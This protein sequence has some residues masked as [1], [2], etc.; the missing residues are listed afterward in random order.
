L[1]A[2]LD[3]IYIKTR[4]GKA[5]VRLV[6]H[7]FFQGRF[8]TTKHR[9]L[10]SF[11]LAEMRF[12]TMLPPLKSANG[13]IYIMGM[14]RSG[15]TI[16]G[17]VL[18]MHRQVGFLNEPKLI[19]YSVDPK[20]DVNGNF[21]NGPAQYR[22][23]VG[24]ASPASRRRI[25]R[26]YSFYLTLTG[27]RRIVDKNPEAVYRIPYLRE[28][29]P[30]ARF[31]FLVRNGWDTVYSTTAWS[32]REGR[33]VKGVVED[34]WGA[35]QRK[36]KF[37]VDQLVPTDPLLSARQNEIAKFNRHE[38]MAA[39][40]WTISVREG[41][42]WLEKLPRSVHLIRYEHLTE[43]PAEALKALLDFCELPDDEVFL[44][45]A[46]QVLVPGRTHNAQSDL[47]PAIESLFLDTMSK[48]G[49]S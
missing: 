3:P 32:K 11:L 7:L 6:S 23:A 26:I 20:D 34:W 49:Y 10:N 16:L 27:S 38:D 28:L 39:V 45:Y 24:D 1:I 47:S 25:Q 8:L 2:E 40:E 12:V 31:L 43:K 18:S 36:W 48:L 35:D 4:P 15:S 29:F 21:Y 37:V 13:P 46:Q 41:L 42:Q 17:K 44:D 33:Q 30:D 19:W 14:G 9:W 5:L 22:F